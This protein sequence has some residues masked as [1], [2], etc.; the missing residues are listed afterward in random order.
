MSV[1]A[2]PSVQLLALADRPTGFTILDPSLRG[3]RRALARAIHR[4]LA[5]GSIVVRTPRTRPAIYMTP[6]S[7]AAARASFVGQ[8][9]KPGAGVLFAKG[10]TVTYPA[11]YRFAQCGS[12]QPRF[13][14]LTSIVDTPVVSL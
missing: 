8:V 6:R 3:S 1:P 2:N 10:A 11:G 14:G 12:W 7:L 13:A 9:K 5:A 4:L